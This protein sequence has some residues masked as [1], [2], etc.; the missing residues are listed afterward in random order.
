VYSICPSV[1]NRRVHHRSELLLIAGGSGVGKSTVAAALHRLLSAQDV[2]HALIEGDNLDLAHP[3]PCMLG[4]KLA[5]RNLTAIWANY[6]AVGHTRLIYVNTASARATVIH[7]LVAA[8]GENPVI[9]AVI[10]A[11]TDAATVERLAMREVG[12]SLQE[13]A[14]RSAAAARLLEREAPAWA[15]RI[16]TDGRTPDGIA[17]ELAMLTRWIPHSD[18]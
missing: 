9:H 12:I 13:H 2:A 18:T 5:E 17:E 6:K 14:A 15:S 4:Q 1:E 8:M 16:S 3:T 11:A 7:S 10:L